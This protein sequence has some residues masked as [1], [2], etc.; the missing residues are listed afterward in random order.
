MAKKSRLNR[1]RLLVRQLP[2]LETW[3]FFLFIMIALG[4]APGAKE[5]ITYIYHGYV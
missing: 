4:F 1:R 5:D 2:G 3:Q